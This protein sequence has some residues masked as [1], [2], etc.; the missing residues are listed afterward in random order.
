MSEMR[1]K[2]NSFALACQH[3]FCTDCW[4]QNLSFHVSQGIAGINVKCMQAGCTLMVAHSVFERFLGDDERTL[5]WRWLSLSF[6]RSS[7]NIQSCSND[8]C[9]V[10][11]EVQPN[12]SLME[13]QCPL[14]QKLTCFKCG[15]GSHRPVDCDMVS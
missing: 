4:R 8:R 13:V 3:S 2:A 9:D 14:C 10:A 1:V 12:R 11:F 15:R 7:I 5:Y 6:I